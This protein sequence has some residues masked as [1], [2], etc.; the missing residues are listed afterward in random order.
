M[1][2]LRSPSTVLGGCLAAFALMMTPGCASGGDTPSP[3]GTLHAALGMDGPAHDI[4]HIGFR[5]L[6]A[7]ADCADPAA[8]VVV[9]PAFQ[10]LE[11]ESLPPWLEPDPPGGDNHPF[12]DLY[13]VLPPGTYVVCARAMTTAEDGT[14][15]PSEHC[16]AT[17]GEAT[18][19][20]EQTTETLLLIQCLGDPTGGLDVVVGLN[21]P[22]QIDDLTIDPSKFVT[23]C[24]TAKV[25]VTATDPNGDA[26]SYSWSEVLADGTTAP[27]EGDGNM[28][29]YGSLVPGAH[30]ILVVVD[31]GHGATAQMSFPI[32]VSLDGDCQ[33]APEGD[34]CVDNGPDSPGCDDDGITECVCALDPF[35]CDVTWDAECAA[36]A[37]GDCGAGCGIGVV[38]GDGSCDAA[39]GE[40]CETCPDDCGAC[41]T[42]GD[43][44]CDAAGGEDCGNCEADC[45]ACVTCGDGVCDAAGGEDCGNC[46]ADCGACVTCGDGVC[47]AAGGEDCGNCEADCGACASCGD[48]IC[49]NTPGEACD[50]CPS[51]CGSC[52]GDGVCVS[53]IGED[54]STCE[55]DCGPCAT[56][57]DGICGNTPGED[58]D[59]CAADCGPCPTCG[60]GIC[61]NT[62]GEACD[63]CA[64]DCGACCGDGVCDA[65]V[66]ED[67]ASCA[68]DCGACATCGDG[69]CGNTPGEDCVTC[70][71]DCG[72]CCGDGVCDA[73]IGEDCVT[74][75]GDCGS[76]CGDGVCDAGVGEAC[77]TCESDCGA[78]VTCGDGVCDA[79]GGEACGNCE[80]DCGA[81]ATCGDGICGNTPGEACDTCEADCGVCPS[82]FNGTYAGDG[83]AT[84]VL[85]VPALNQ[86]LTVTCS[87][88]FDATV[89]EAADPQ[90][91]GVLQCPATETL[92]GI[93]VTLTTADV[94]GSFAP[95]G[96]AGGMISIAVD[97]SAGPFDPV[98][99]P[100]TGAFADGTLT[101]GLSE[102]ISFQFEPIPGFVVDA[103]A[104]V[105]GSFSGTK[106]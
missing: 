54:C 97:T 69:I 29:E 71:G 23:S 58:C 21:D 51:D 104:Q 81:C 22:P 1:R 30:Q 47:D 65:A 37:S 90:I 106:Q 88:A 18:V 42:C 45:G 89:D 103:T 26:L 25:T 105:D 10:P 64:A 8:A 61:G 63:T 86:T 49:G 16:G 60:D 39:G 78:C 50:T 92:L 57:G 59:T 17:S 11:S 99:A 14:M 33:P 85:T 13:S 12:A 56:C 6:A 102:T 94:A 35:C 7:G 5:I 67:C 31:D 44:V 75:E 3:T 40:D 9:G 19:V 101:G 73:T 87:G 24:E 27:L 80:A 38:C 2:L 34:C 72:S 93:T 79:A 41:V 55:A 70:E 98:A 96:S 68:A 77:D 46:E 95:D 53:T 100:W 62:P 32:H 15:V 4:T 43:G 83:G 66:G 84:V 82:P 28:L 20:A 52:C 76:C 91:Q 36:Q 48:G 74:C